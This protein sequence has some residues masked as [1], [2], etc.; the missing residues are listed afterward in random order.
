MQS[1]Y[2]TA[3]GRASRLP[4]SYTAGMN[5]G[6]PRSCRVGGLDVGQKVDHTVL[7]TRRAEEG[8]DSRAWVVERITQL[9][10]GLL[11]I[12]QFQLLQLEIDQLDHLDHLAVDSGGS[13]QGLP[14]HIRGAGLRTLVPVVI[15]GGVGKGKVV[16]GRVT[17]GKTA[18]IQDMLQ[19]FYHRELRVD[20]EAEGRDLL[21]REMRAFRYVSD[22]RF[23]K[24]EARPGEHDDAVLALALGA[25]LA[26]R[27]EP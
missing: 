21:E 14:G 10:L 15:T 2:S 8:A 24:A 16:S 19:Q 22:G 23:R 12:E 27:V 26:R 5:T 4:V 3:A 17:V 25:H 18:L 11:F 6:T 7:A 1:F 20:P 9:P 13:G